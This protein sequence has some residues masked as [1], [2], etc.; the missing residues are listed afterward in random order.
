LFEFLP[1]FSLLD[2]VV[3]AF[4]KNVGALTFL[5]SPWELVSVP[6]WSLAMALD[7]QSQAIEMA[8]NQQIILFLMA[9]SLK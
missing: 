2:N 5:T 9:T 8:L 6:I 3:L 4:K 7:A 1:W